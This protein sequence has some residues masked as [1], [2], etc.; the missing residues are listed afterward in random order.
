MQWLIEQWC[1]PVE[2]NYPT[3]SSRPSRCLQKG[4]TR[5]SRE[6]KRQRETAWE[7]KPGEKTCIQEQRSAPLMSNLTLTSQT[8]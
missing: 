1:C 4:E 7:A 5:L 2:A 8:E 3:H 6:R